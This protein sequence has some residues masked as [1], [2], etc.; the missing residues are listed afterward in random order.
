MT[1]RMAL[2]AAVALVPGA[3]A[4]LAHD[5]HDH[6]IMGTV[7]ARHATRFEVKTPGGETLSIAISEKTV[8]VRGKRKAPLAD[9]QPG[10]RV[11]VNIGN[12]EDPLIAR[13]IQLGVTETA[14]K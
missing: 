14:A 5:G 13:E 3:R 2:L 10:R 6:K 1:R 9:V 7:I 12:G 4:L 8:V 11:V